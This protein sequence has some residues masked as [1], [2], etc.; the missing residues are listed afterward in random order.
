MTIHSLDLLEKSLDESKNQKHLAPYTFE[1]ISYMLS[2][3]TTV[4]STKVAKMEEEE[5]RN[6]N[7]EDSSIKLNKFKSDLINAITSL[8]IVQEDEQKDYTTIG[9]FDAKLSP[10]V[11]NEIIKKVNLRIQ[12]DVLQV[13]SK[14]FEIDSKKKKKEEESAKTNDTEGLRY[15]FKDRQLNLK[16][17]L[18]DY[19][20]GKAFIEDLC[21]FIFFN[22]LFFILCF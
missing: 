12:K 10:A 8:D 15:E 2:C 17:F 5:K 11:E 20:S 21:I 9:K 1:H 13:I 19:L 7:I 16:W 6:D 18:P 3:L 4:L 14:T 22:I